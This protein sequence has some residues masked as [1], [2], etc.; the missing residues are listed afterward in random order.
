MFVKKGEAGFYE[1]TERVLNSIML[2]TTYI[3]N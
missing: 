3:T 2:I 1:D